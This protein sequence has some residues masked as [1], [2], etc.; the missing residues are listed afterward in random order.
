MLGSV[1]IPKDW[2]AGSTKRC[3]VKI[4]LSCR[5][6]RLF[7]R[8]DSVQHTREGSVPL[9]PKTQCKSAVAKVEGQL[10][11]RRRV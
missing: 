8:V 10:Q 7:L 3:I 9:L 5:P 11:N 1:L 4:D 6:G 2:I